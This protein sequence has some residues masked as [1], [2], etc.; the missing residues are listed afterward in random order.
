MLALSLGAIRFWSLLL[1]HKALYPTWMCDGVRPPS[2]LCSLQEAPIPVSLRTL[3][4]A[5]KALIPKF[6]KT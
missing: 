2:P 6:C 5:S 4:S 1:L 3:V